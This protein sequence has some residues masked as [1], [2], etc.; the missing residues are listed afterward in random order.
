MN[1]MEMK[2]ELWKAFSRN[3]PIKVNIMEN[4]RMV[5]KEISPD[6]NEYSNM[7]VKQS[8]YLN[9]KINKPSVDSIMGEIRNSASESVNSEVDKLMDEIHKESSNSDLN[10]IQI[11][12]ENEKTISKTA[13]SSDLKKGNVVIIKKDSEYYMIGSF[14]NEELND[15]NNIISKELKKLG[16]KKV[17][18]CNTATATA[19]VIYT[20]KSGIIFKIDDNGNIIVKEEYEGIHY[21]NKNIQNSNSFNLD[22][23]I[24]NA[25]MGHKVLL[26]TQLE[27]YGIDN[28]WGEIL[29][30]LNSK[31]MSLDEFKKFVED[32][33]SI[34][35]KYE[36]I[37]YNI[38]DSNYKKI[39][40]S[41]PIEDEISVKISS[42]IGYARNGFKKGIIAVILK[43]GID[44]IWIDIADGLQNGKISKVEYKEFV[45]NL[46]KLFSKEEYEKYKLFTSEHYKALQEG[47]ILYE[48][49]SKKLDTLTEDKLDHKTAPSKIKQNDNTENTS[50]EKKSQKV[51]S[52]KK[53]N[54]NLKAIFFERVNKTKDWWGNLSPKTKGIIVAATIITVGVGALV[55]N[56]STVKDILEN[57]NDISQLGVTPTSDVHL[58]SSS[59]NSMV[60]PLKHVTH[61]V[62]NTFSNLQS[63][64]QT[65]GV[66]WNSICEGHIGY[67]TAADAF[68]HMN[69]VTL[70][71]FF[72]KDPSSGIIDVYNMANGWMNLTK[73]QLNDP[74]LLKTL[75]QDPNNVI[76]VKDAWFNLS[77]VLSEV[78]KGGRVL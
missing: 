77:D 17:F 4:G 36:L 73:E 26:K 20:I 8:S 57:V 61:Y 45:N 69:G 64:I 41:Y 58:N 52:R 37:K 16:I 76:H 46:K 53:A 74:E 49:G 6:S 38:F 65:S 62:Q 66:N 70:N 47:K 2:D 14:S 28:I 34:Y 43:Y 51:R 9:D 56:A 75:S 30:K 71:S 7:Y 5:V 25:S 78:I 27:K 63:T 22:S 32:I 44:N 68:N 15:S 48:S 50:S 10:I 54:E 39:I 13:I 24:K 19:N 60:E 35:D 29:L 55:L 33:N 40:E 23:I 18:V 3:L 31:E 42:V 11:N 12:Q 21:I 67:K 59:V 1:Y 72:G